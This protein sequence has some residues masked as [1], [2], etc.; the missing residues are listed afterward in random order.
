MCGRDERSSLADDMHA[1]LCE[2]GTQG[3]GAQRTEHFSMSIL[4]N[5]I[6]LYSGCLLIATKYGSIALHGA[7]HACGPPKSRILREWIGGPTN[8]C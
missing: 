7:D 6:P 3:A 1:A 2:R 4:Q 8:V 5:L